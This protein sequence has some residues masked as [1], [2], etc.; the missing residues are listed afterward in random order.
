MLSQ[1]RRPLWWRWCWWWWWWTSVSRHLPAPLHGGSAAFPSPNHFY[2]DTCS[3]LALFH[4]LS[5]ITFPTPD[6]FPPRF[7]TRIL[8]FPPLLS[9]GFVVCFDLA[10]INRVRG[11]IYVYILC[12]L[13]IFISTSMLLVSAR[14]DSLRLVKRRKSILQEFLK[15]FR[16]SSSSSVLL[17]KFWKG[18]KIVVEI[19]KN[20]NSMGTKESLAR[21]ELFDSIKWINVFVYLVITNYKPKSQIFTNRNDS[22]VNCN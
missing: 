8:W 6:V 10:R 17:I 11:F 4:R 19:F 15:G 18:F 2:S 16:Q 14:W 9:R 21:E 5:S 3:G 22:S 12:L 20:E 13:F 1:H 7:R